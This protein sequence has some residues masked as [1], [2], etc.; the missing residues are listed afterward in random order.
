[1]ILQNE[2]KLIDARTIK[3]IKFLD[4]LYPLQLKKDALKAELD[5]K[6]TLNLGDAEIVRKQFMVDFTYNS[7]AVEGNTFTLK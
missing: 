3:G 2:P 6:R 1:M 7:N 4:G 5:S